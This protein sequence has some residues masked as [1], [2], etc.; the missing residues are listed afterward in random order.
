MQVRRLLLDRVTIAVAGVHAEKLPFV[1]HGAQAKVAGLLGAVGYPGVD[2]ADHAVESRAAR[3]V[4]MVAGYR[5]ERRTLV[6]L[7]LRDDLVEH[8]KDV[9]GKLLYRA[10][11][12]DVA[13]V[14]DDVGLELP[15]R[16]TEQR[17]IIRHMRAP[18]ADHQDPAVLRQA[19]IDDAEIEVRRGRT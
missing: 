19:I 7:N 12:I 8:I 10:G 17:G 1:V 2:L 15:E 4:I 16:L 18:V 3:V 14:D 13:E 5:E 6:R 11:I 9:G